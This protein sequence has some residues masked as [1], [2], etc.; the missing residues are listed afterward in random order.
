MDG[1]LTLDWTPPARRRTDPD[2]CRAPHPA[3]LSHGRLVALLAHD[4]HP[5]GLTD[6]ELAELTGRAQTSIGK[7]RGELTGAGLVTATERRR[8]SPSGSPAVVWQITD[9]GRRLAADAREAVA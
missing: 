6:F 1:Q 7:R 4:D 5:G 3:R 2:T 9:A 8:P